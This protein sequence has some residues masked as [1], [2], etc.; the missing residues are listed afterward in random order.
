MQRIAVDTNIL[1]RLFVADDLP[2]QAAALE[3]LE[4]AQSVAVPTTVFVETVWVLTRA[5]KLPAE[6]VLRQLQNF[7]ESVPGLIVNR[8]ESDA[9]F[10]MMARN[11]DFADGI[12][13]FSGQKL[14]AACF[15]TFDKKAAK[16]LAAQDR[17][18]RLL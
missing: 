12:N 17:E 5:Y 2:Q 8:D 11:G 15:V 6:A 13:E 7:V 1:V 3:I 10:A 4:A 9:G 18:V 16:L 14:G